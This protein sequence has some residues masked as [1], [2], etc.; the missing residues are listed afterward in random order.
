MFKTFEG[1]R[2][3]PRGGARFSAPRRSAVA[4]S[5]PLEARRLLAAVHGDV[6]NDM[7]DNAARDAGENGVPGLTVYLDAN[8]NGQLD[9]GEESRISESDGGYCFDNLA[10]GHH[11]IGVTTWE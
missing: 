2:P 6:F 1:C 7:N 4:G 10:H 9:A 3:R 8:L 11:T 5:E